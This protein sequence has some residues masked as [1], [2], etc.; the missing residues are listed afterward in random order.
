MTP[1]VSRLVRYSDRSSKGTRPAAPL[2]GPVARY[3]AARPFH[4]ASPLSCAST[5]PTAIA[6]AC[7]CRSPCEMLALQPAAGTGRPAPFANQRSSEKYSPAGPMARH[8]SRIERPSS[9]G[10]ASMGPRCNS[11]A[12]STAASG[13]TTGVAK[14]TSSRAKTTP[15]APKSAFSAE[16][17][18]AQSKS[19]NPVGGRHSRTVSAG[20]TPAGPNHACRSAA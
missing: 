15:V 17:V 12:Q 14:P 13:A 11:D 3:Q 4:Q 18:A 7:T 5:A 19:E 6:V 9:A 10:P 1:C 16:G 2:R 8:Q 20:R